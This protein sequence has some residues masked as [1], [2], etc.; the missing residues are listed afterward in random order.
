MLKACRDFAA[1]VGIRFHTPEEYFLQEEVKPFVRSF[2]PAVYLQESSGKSISA[3]CA[4]M[5]RH[6]SHTRSETQSN[7]D[8]SLQGAPAFSKKNDLDIVILCGS[9]GAGKSSFYWRH[10]QPLGYARVNQDILKTVSVPI[11]VDST[12][13]AA[14]RSLSNTCE[15]AR[16]V[17]QGGYFTRRGRDICGGW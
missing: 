12:W 7:T 17:P 8:I 13:C 5:F 10:L 1:N 14:P 11:V 15:T 16:E 2:D 3:T 9:P 4:C 6:A